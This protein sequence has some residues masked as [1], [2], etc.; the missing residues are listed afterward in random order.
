MTAAHRA[1]VTFGSAPVFVD[2]SGRRRR[3][4]TLLGYLGAA[5]CAAYVAAFGVTMTTSAGALN[6]VAGSTLT[7]TP[8]PAEDDGDDG[9]G[10][11][12]AVLPGA[13]VATPSPAVAVAPVAAVRSVVAAPV[14]TTA[15]ESR[16]RTGLV[17]LRRREPAARTHLAPRAV[18][19][20][21]P[22]PRRTA[23]VAPAKAPVRAAAP[24]KAAPVK[25]APAAGAPATPRSTGTGTSGSGT[26]T[27]HRHRHRHDGDRHRPAP[28]PAPGR[29]WN[30]NRNRNRHRHRYRHDDRNRHPGAPD[31]RRDVR[32]PHHRPHR[33][34]GSE[35][36][37]GRHSTAPTRAGWR[38]RSAP[39]PPSGAARRRRLI[40]RP[41][42]LLV[43]VAL[44]MFG[45]LLMV[46]GLASSEVGVDPPAA[47]PAAAAMDEVPRTVTD[48][49]PVVDT[50]GPEPRSA[51]M[52]ARTI[53]L[54]FDDGPDPTWT[55]QVLDV[56]RRHQVPA[57]FFV[58]G[59]RAATN[60][61]LLR[62]IR[63]AGSEVGIHSFTHPDL[64]SVSG[65]RLDR[66]LAET[67]LVLDGAIGESSYLLRPPYSSS[68]N[69]VDNDALRSFREAGADGY[70]TVLSD[71]D[72]RDWQRP[73]IDAIVRAAQPV[74]G[75]GGIVLLHDAR[76]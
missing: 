52:P 30:R 75:A 37:M 74:N 76:R 57:T 11:Q 13:P 4:L 16:A 48:G 5:A 21:A 9:D 32:C 36:T 67:Q 44:I 71:I 8:L 40:P 10:A 59:S 51:A 29:N 2:A 54:T 72:S 42:V 27:R 60:P 15:V 66:E 7:P 3:A 65:M 18:H 31:A 14:R 73:G 70:V 58:V 26:G 20:V 33:D 50:R 12:A 45:C 1:G 23:G 28:A 38:A 43:V 39:Q 6:A 46:N 22:A 61:G 17:E 24:V 34:P 41:G 68:P 55:P 69:A 49:G 35:L 19:R 25:A 53:A 56:L 62:D 47:V 63:A 64:A